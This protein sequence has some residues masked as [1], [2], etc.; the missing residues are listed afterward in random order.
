MKNGLRL[1]LLACG[2]FLSIT[3]SAQSYCVPGGIGF[4][5]CNQG[6]SDIDDVT[7]GAFSDLNSGCNFP[8]NLGYVDLTSQTIYAQM[9][10]PILQM[11]ESKCFN[12]LPQVQLQ[13]VLLLC[14][15]V[16]EFLQQE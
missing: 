3:I 13:P 15:L 6:V 9:G 14:L 1:A 12:L 10:A 7:I 5:W 8:N 11:R 4:Q 2:F 16:L